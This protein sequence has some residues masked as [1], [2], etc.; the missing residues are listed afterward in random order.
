MRPLAKIIPVVWVLTLCSC[1]GTELI[2]DPIIPEKLT[3]LPRIDSLAVGQEQIFSVQ[4]SNQYGEEEPVYDIA[5]S[6]SDS[7]ILAIDA[8]GRAKVMTTGTATIYAMNGM[9]LDSIVL[10]RLTGPGS[11][12]DGDTIFFKRGTFMKVDDHYF[13]EGQV[14]VQNVNGTTQIRTDLDFATS[15][16][17]SVYL[18]LTNHITGAYTVTPGGHAV[19]AVSA[20]ITA[21]KLATFT[22]AQTWT[23]PS[24]VNPADYKYVVLYC[25]LGPVFGAAELQ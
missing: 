1:V 10:N 24:D 20:Q 6:S 9:V 2:D 3:I 4:Y 23:V 17:P 15:A 12:S 16:G 21:N 22:G 14:Y 18:L 25:V 8:S 11:T 5:W 13:A 7:E 19:N